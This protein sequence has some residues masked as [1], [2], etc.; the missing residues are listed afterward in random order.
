M[1][2]LRP[3]F[4]PEAL[5]CHPEAPSGHPGAPYGYLEAPCGYPEAPRGHPKAPYGHPE[6]P[7]GYLEAPTSL[8]EAINDQV[9]IT[10]MPKG[11][12]WSSVPFPQLRPL[13]AY[14][15]YSA[16]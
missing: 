15:F 12:V 3:L 14:S 6:A 4:P 13:S 5:S 9:A 11:N 2:I 10:E 16:Y 8:P 7:S 1:A